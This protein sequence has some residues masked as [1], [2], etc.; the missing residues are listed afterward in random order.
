[1]TQYRMTEFLRKG[2]IIVD[3]DL[4]N[5]SS[6]PVSKLLGKM[7]LDNFESETFDFD[8][9]VGFIFIDEGDIY[10]SFLA[11]NLCQETIE[12]VQRSGEEPT[13]VGR[14]RFEATGPDRNLTFR[15]LVEP[16]RRP[17]NEFPSWWHDFGKGDVHRLV[18]AVEANLQR[19]E[20][21]GQ[22]DTIGFVRQLAITGDPRAIPVLR[23]AV[24]HQRL[25]LR[26]DAALALHGLGDPDGVAALI[27]DY[28]HCPIDETDFHI[29][30][31]LECT[32]D[33][34]AEA[35]V[36]ERRAAEAKREQEKQDRVR[37]G[38]C[39]SCGGALGVLDK[40]AG[41]QSHKHCY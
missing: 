22:S 38:L 26:I 39:V 14:I 2:D 31:A 12:E 27:H 36:A 19:R 9:A 3:P 5:R 4:Q 29:L 25:S 41:R 35:I 34:R 10:Q 7:F 13:T 37:N 11:G 21:L 8:G 20:P 1:M 18:A 24:R 32:H 40:L 23:K 6:N 16:I 30:K 17:W 28:Q 33:P 15:I